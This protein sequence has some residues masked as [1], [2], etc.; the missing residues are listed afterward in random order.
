[1]AGNLAVT[2]VLIPFPGRQ[3]NDRA[4][5]AERAPL[6]LSCCGSSRTESCP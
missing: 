6:S 3:S 2:L 5:S 1:M 4:T